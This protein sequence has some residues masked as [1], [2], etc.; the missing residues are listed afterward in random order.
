MTQHTLI[1]THA[2]LYASQFDEDREAMIQNALKAGVSRI[3]LPNIDI[4]STEPLLSLVSRFPDT[5]FPM[6]GLHPCS[7][8]HGFETTLKLMEAELATGKYF[9]VG[10]TGLDYYWDKTF[11][12]EQKKSL[13][14]HINWAKQFDLPIILHARD[15]LDDLI[16]MISS[17]HNNKLRGIFHCFT[18]NEEQA[19]KIIPLEN[20]YFGIGGVLT[21]KN[22][23]L[24]KIVME[25]PLERIVIET[26]S[27]YLAPAPHRGKRNESAYITLVANKLAEI[28]S[29]QTQTIAEIT[30]RN[31]LILFDNASI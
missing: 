29:V 31:A 17:N 16:E 26:D 5:C 25:I 27:P 10:E 22:S 7:V 23:G 1:D 18:G 6:M 12:T 11:I 2:H 8:D 3:Y 4:E 13:L 15:S 28:K 9:G 19:K 14:I 20:F 24:D 21:F 30:T